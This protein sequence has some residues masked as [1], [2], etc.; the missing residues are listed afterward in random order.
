MGAT[1]VTG[2]VRTMEA[3]DLEAVLMLESASFSEPWP[4]A[5]FVDELSRRSRRYFVFEEDGTVTGYGGLLVAGDD[6]HVM[7]LAVDPAVRRRGVG[8]RLLLALIDASIDAGARHMTLEV[9]E[10]NSAARDLYAA[11]GFEE[12]GL[13]PGYYRSE[14]AVVMWAVDIDRRPFRMRL[15][16]LRERYA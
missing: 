4:A 13:R 16:N 12:V 1:R 9:R 15:N 14:D 11:F 10:S 2:R 7:T 8:A 3:G 6:A 5:M